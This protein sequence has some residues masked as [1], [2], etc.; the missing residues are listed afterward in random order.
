M[1][2]LFCA[3]L[4]LSAL[5]PPSLA[6]AAVISR[7]WKTP[8]DGL[9]T[10]DDVNQREWLDLSQTILSSQFPGA[11]RESRFTYVV[12]QTSSGGSF[13]GFTAAT[14]ADVTALAQSAGIDTT[15]LNYTLNHTATSTLQELLG[16]TAVFPTGNTTSGLLSELTTLPT[17]TVR[18]RVNFTVSLIDDRAGFQIVN[19]VDLLLSPPPGMMLYRAV[20]EPAS[21][22]IAVACLLA[23]GGVR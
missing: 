6:C 17:M 21:I 18:K 20:P 10:Y 19:E 11:D 13:Q 15:T 22:L 2:L 4:A 14:V 12:G 9:L 23:R 3:A 7:D 5:I 8:G 16:I 1:R